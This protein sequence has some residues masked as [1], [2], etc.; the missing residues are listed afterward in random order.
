MKNSDLVAFPSIILAVGFYCNECVFVSVYL[1]V[2]R[3]L[4]GNFVL[5]RELKKILSVEMH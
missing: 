4:S 1:L 2:K 3:R 5:I